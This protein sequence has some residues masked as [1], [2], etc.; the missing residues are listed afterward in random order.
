MTDREHDYNKSIP[1][2]NAAGGIIVDGEH[3]GD[4][5]RC[6]HCSGHWVPIKGSGITRGYCLNCKGPTC[7]SPRCDICIPLEKRLEGWEAAKPL[8]QVLKELDSQ[9]KTIHLS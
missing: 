3:V 4:T 5:L 7:G 1:V 2:H 6:V 9:G 8:D